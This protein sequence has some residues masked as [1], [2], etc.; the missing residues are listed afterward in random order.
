[1]T[2]ANAQ[3]HDRPR[4]SSHKRNTSPDSLL[5]LRLFPAHTV[6]FQLTV[7]CRQRKR[8]VPS[9]QH[10]GQGIA[11]RLWKVTKRK[12]VARITA[13]RTHILCPPFQ[14]L[15]IF[16]RSSIRKLRTLPRVGCPSGACSWRRVEIAPCHWGL[17]DR[18]WNHLPRVVPRLVYVRFI[19][20]LKLL[21]FF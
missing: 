17:M 21:P 6:S 3:C 13:R 4:A 10:F 18:P 8:G 1:M 15:A 2:A 5:S 12:H 19:L 20:F 14:K 7:S 9:I 11:K 16:D